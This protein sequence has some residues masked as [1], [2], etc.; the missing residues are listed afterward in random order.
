[1]LV[2]GDCLKAKLVEQ[3]IAFNPARFS[4]AYKTKLEEEWSRRRRQTEDYKP[5]LTADHSYEEKP[6]DQAWLMKESDSC[7][8]IQVSPNHYQGWHLVEDQPLRKSSVEQAD[9]VDVRLCWEPSN[10]TEIA[11]R[12]SLMEATWREMYLS[13][14]ALTGRRQSGLCWWL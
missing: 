13:C 14:R 11:H 12:R 1:M 9:L 3:R 6:H 5:P 10:P 2:W 7:S 8:C 4:P